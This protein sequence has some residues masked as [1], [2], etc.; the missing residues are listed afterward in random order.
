M[1]TPFDF[2]SMFRFSVGFD[3]VF[4]PLESAGRAQPESWPPYNIEKTGE[5]RYRVM[6]VV[7]GYSSGEITVSGA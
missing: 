2:S 7:A 3:R 6:M 4:D 5:D 1:R